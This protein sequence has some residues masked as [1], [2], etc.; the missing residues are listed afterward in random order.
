MR[1]CNLKIFLAVIAIMT[2]SCSEEISELQEASFIKFYGSYKNDMGKDVISL[3]GGGFAVTGNMVPDSIAKMVLVLTDEAGNQ[4]EG[5]PRVYG[6][7]LK[8]GGNAILLLEDG[9]LLGGTL[10]DTAVD[11]ELQTDMYLVRTNFSGDTIWTRRFGG[12]EN[13]V[14]NHMAQRNTGGFV[15]AGKKTT[16]ENEDLWILMVDEEGNRLY[17]FTGS[18]TDDDDE[19]NIVV[20]T[21]DGYLCACSYDEG[22]MEGTDIFLV[23]IDENCNIIDSKA[24]GTDDDDYARAIVKHGNDYM[25]MGYT[26]NSDNGLNQTVLY[27][28]STENGLITNAEMFATITD[29]VAD[30][31]GEDC[32]V[33]SEGNIAVFGTI[34]LNEN[35]DMY[36]VI[37]DENGELIADPVEYG[38]VGNQSGMALDI[39]NDGGLILT[40]YNSLEGN[41]LISLIKT[42]ALGGL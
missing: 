11:G 21:K 15:L 16:N 31:T 20:E 3:E 35:R 10:S 14:L 4:L 6:G 29:L 9:Y 23:S 8:T 26:E 7:G 38:E 25:V 36:L 24:L 13:D 34:N 37:F 18:D 28:F 32:V 40:G 22:S 39:T 41:S 33:T 42:D 30:I 12:D 5:S 17:D 2:V 1:H 27:R 19:A